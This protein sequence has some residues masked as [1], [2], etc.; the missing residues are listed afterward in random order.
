MSEKNCLRI[1]L[2][3]NASAPRRW[4]IELADRLRRQGHSVDIAAEPGPTAP[5]GLQLLMQLEQTVY[6]LPPQHA[7]ATAPAPPLQ[8]CFHASPELIIDLTSAQPEEGASRRLKPFYDSQASEAA[9]VEALLGRRAPRIDLRLYE[10]GQGSPRLIATADPALENRDLF[11]PGFD[12]VVA[13][14]ASLITGAVK[15]LATQGEIVTIEPTAASNAP[16]ASAGMFALTTLAHKVANRLTRLAVH[17]EH[18][19]VGWRRLKGGDAIADTLAWPAGSYQYLPDDAKR[20]FADPFIFTHEGRSF[21]FCEEYPYAAGKG[22]LTAF[23]LLANGEVGPP[24]PVMEQAWHLSYP[25]VFARDGEIWMIPET[26]AARR[27]ELY[28]ATGFPDSWVREAVLIDDIRA[29]DATLIE[30]E[31]RFWL[32]ATVA[33]DSLSD[34]DALCLFYADALH[35]PWT[36]HPANPVLIDASAARPAGAMFTRNGELW[37]PAQDCSRGYGGGLALCSVDRLDEEDFRQTVH[38]RL[39]PPLTW[40]AHGAHTLNRAG[41][42]EV[43]DVV[44]SRWRR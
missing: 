34:W 43:I 10:P 7:T 28:R 5:P 19:R 27:I 36:A 32:F 18:F 31:G 44:G 15:K 17:R 14:V 9:A 3:L 29:A 4:H 8:V 42:I 2:L 20:Y 23:E 24:R 12:A 30:H 16:P 35:G 40:R 41:N 39:T 33:E 11:T 26:C 21:I 37:R 6:G 13:C 38:A 1:R 22:V 25:Q